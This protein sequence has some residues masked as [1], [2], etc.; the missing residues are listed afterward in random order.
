MDYSEILFEQDG[1]IAYLTLNRPDIRNAITSDV[2]INE[3][4]NVCDTRYRRMK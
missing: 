3:I 4:V 1:S 2:M